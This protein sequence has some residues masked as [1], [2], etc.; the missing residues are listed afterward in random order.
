MLINDPAIIDYS[1]LL[2]TRP[3]DIRRV[4][5]S[6]LH[7]SSDEPALVQAFLAML[8]DLLVLP[9]LQQFYILGDWFDAWIGD[10]SYLSLSQSAAE[11]HW[12]TPIIDKLIQLNEQGCSIKIMHGNR[13]FVIGQAFCD[14]FH[15]EL[16]YEPYILNIGSKTFRLEHGDALCTDDKSYQRFRSIIRNPLTKWILLKQ[17]LQKRESLAKKMRQKSASGKSN[18]SMAIMDVNQKAVIKALQPVDALL[19][20]HTHRP[21]IHEVVTDKTANRTTPRYVLGDWRVINPASSYEKVEAIIAVSTL[22][23]TLEDSLTST[24]HNQ[25]SE[26][27]LQPNNNECL[28][29]VKFSVKT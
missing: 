8:D 21:A 20:G 27:S 28:Q 4:I 17:P 16:I 14:L 15:G 25:T 6:D 7:L 22:P 23:Q 1:Y 26:K 5:I 9:N 10:D 19:H 12:L 18:K 29:L 2:T 11:Q 13:D 3:Y 24:H